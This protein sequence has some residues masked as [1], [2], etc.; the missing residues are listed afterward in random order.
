MNNF[1][2]E[3][4]KELAEQKEIE[5]TESDFRDNREY[6]KARIKAEIARSVWGTEK[7][8]QVLLLYDNQY[9]KAIDLFYNLEELLQVSGSRDYVEIED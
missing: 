8:Y 4:L 7:Y 5:F 2:L 1:L 9:N 6:F 3:G